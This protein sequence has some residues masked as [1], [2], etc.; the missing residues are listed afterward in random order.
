MKRNY[1]SL[2]VLFILM[3]FVS[4]TPSFGVS[5]T[6]NE[7]TRSESSN[8]TTDVAGHPASRFLNASVTYVMRNIS[9]TSTA[10]V[11]VEDLITL[12]IKD[13]QTFIGVFN[14]TIPT[15][16]E[17]YVVTAEFFSKQAPTN[18]G[19]LAESNKKEYTKFVG[20]E[21]TT[22]SIRIDENG[23]LA[24]NTEL[25]QIYALL[26]ASN[27]MAFEGI[28]DYQRSSFISPVRPIF[29]NLELE[30]S[31]IAMRIGAKSNS[32]N[33]NEMNQTTNLGSSYPTLKDATTLEWYNYSR[34]AFDPIEGLLLDYDYTKV[35]I[36]STK[37]DPEAALDELV[38]IAG[39]VFPK[40]DR[41][42]KID[43][44]GFVYVTE[45]LTMRNLGAPRMENPTS[46]NLV[47]RISG[48]KM[49]LHKYSK[50]LELYDDQGSLNVGALKDDG[51][52]ISDPQT[53]YN[54]LEV[55]FRNPIYGNEEYTFTVEYMIN[56][57]DIISVN[58]GVYSLNATL[59]SSFNSTVYEL[60]T[61]YEFPAGA[62]LLSNDF[63][64]SSS[65]SIVDISSYAKRSTLSYFNHVE[66]KI[67][68]IN[69][70]YVDNTQFTIKYKYNGL[71][72]VQYILTFIMTL[73][74]LLMAVYV[75][76]NIQLRESKAIKLEKDKIPMDEIDAF[77]KYFTEQFDANNRIAELT[78][79]RRKN[80]LSQREYTGQVKA[81]NKRIRDN[82]SPL[83]KAITDLSKVGSKYERLVSRIMIA[84][85]KI[86]DSRT[87]ILNARKS[88]SKKEINKALYQK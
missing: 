3:M 87:N 50:V 11:A 59:F 56:A 69:A 31:I 12:E 64:S 44:W 48:F 65:T 71:G 7:A 82:N 83:D 24:N 57:T 43:P 16:F 75:L 9:I 76:S 84:N 55:N 21:A 79:K 6:A 42:L 25:V 80:K 20:E 18:T 10:R 54:F 66:M 72:H 73:I 22:Y 15:S 81:I 23:T 4:L 35:V 74:L 62:E 39:F 2:S 53:N 32:F 63:R 26:Q 88:Y 46:L 58:D 70:S 49:Q 19:V 77:I 67:S 86:A 78:E 45:T 8:L 34:E 51:T 17:K 38:S 1:K 27:L 40:A 33:L 30:N 61:V 85:Q 36:D 68:I 52:P 5:G 60:N 37:P 47:H 28:E 13:N 41:R 29:P 14:Y